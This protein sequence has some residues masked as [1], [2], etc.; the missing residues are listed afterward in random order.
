MTESNHTDADGP[1]LLFVCSGNICRSPM[2]AAIAQ[3]AAHE[4]GMHIRVASS[5]T[6]ALTGRPAEETA[7]AV[8]AE[9]GLT[10]DGHS[11]R[12]ATREDVHAAALVVAVTRA[13][14]AWLR[15]HASEA[16]HIVTFDELTGLG[17]IPDP[18]GQ[19]LEEYREVRDALVAGMPRILAAL[20]ARQAASSKDA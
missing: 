5:G 18:Y 4:A 3:A 16:T 10:L 6:G 9:I 11:A 2:A 17:D 12:Q 14:D 1:L 19:S 8:L 13:H 15:M 7:E 20:K